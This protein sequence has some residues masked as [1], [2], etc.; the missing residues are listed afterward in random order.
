MKHQRV[1]KSLVE[2]VVNASLIST[3]GIWLLAGNY[4]G[5]LKV[6]SDCLQVFP[7]TQC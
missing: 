5:L 2:W 6:V 3:A 7:L 1:V 4:D